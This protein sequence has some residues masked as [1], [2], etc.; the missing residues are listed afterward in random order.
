MLKAQLDLSVPCPDTQDF[1]PC[2]GP[3]CS[4]EGE[5]TARASERPA[6]AQAG[7][8]LPGDVGPSDLAESLA[9]HRDPDC[10]RQWGP[11]RAVPHLQQCLRDS[12]QNTSDDIKRILE[13]D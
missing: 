12:A 10:S 8:A 9:G 1:Q 4:D 7:T 2:M 3:G 13:V 5:E 11:P 6:E